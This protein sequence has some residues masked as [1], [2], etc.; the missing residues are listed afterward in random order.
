VREVESLKDF[1]RGGEDDT[2]L[3]R[4]EVGEV[5]GGTLAL[6]LPV[7]LPETLRVREGVLL[8]LGQ[9]VEDGVGEVLREEIPHLPPTGEEQGEG[10]S[11]GEGVTLL[12]PRGERE[13]VLL[14]ERE[15]E[16]V[17]EVEVEVEAVKL[18]QIL[19]RGVEE[20]EPPNHPL[21]PMAFP[22]DWLAVPAGHAVGVTLKQRVGLREPVFLTGEVLPEREEEG[23]REGEGEPEGEG[24]SRGEGEDVRLIEGWLEEDSEVETV[25]LPAAPATPPNLA[26]VR[27]AVGSPSVGVRMADGVAR[28]AVR[29]V[30]GDLVSETEPEGECVPK[31]E[32]EGDRENEGEPLGE[33]E[34]EGL[35]TSDWEGEGEEETE[36]VEGVVVEG[37][38][39][40]LLLGEKLRVKERREDI[41]IVGDFEMD[42]EWEEVEEVFGDREGEGEEEVDW[43]SERL[44][45]S[46]SQV[47]VA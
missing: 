8:P 3:L 14:V 19:E 34:E 27:E 6:G 29:E 32:T 15:G 18:A 40:T 11:E 20:L 44:P 16:G 4:V 45:D 12:L 46:E 39:V 28:A 30:L 42:G 35:N 38:R 13:E 24:L 5:E 36:G 22:G 47:K 43:E 31:G 41:E 10:V 7:I 21:P 26:A 33:P 25:P 2:L 9:R 23:E 37:V 1:E 17:L